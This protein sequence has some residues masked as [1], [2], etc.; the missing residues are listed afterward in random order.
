MQALLQYAP[1]SSF[2]L[3]FWKRA[4]ALSSAVSELSSSAS[5]AKYQ[6]K[7]QCTLRLADMVE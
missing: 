7:T 2:I 1:L 6:L 4:M 5:T 3:C